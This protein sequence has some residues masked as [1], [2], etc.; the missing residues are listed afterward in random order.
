MIFSAAGP[1]ARSTG[2]MV[3]VIDHFIREHAGQDLLLDFEGSE[4]T[5]LARFYA[6]FG[7]VSVPYQRLVMDR[8]PRAVKMLRRIMR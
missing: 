3:R 6:G 2:A 7:S 1:L 4:N 5:G 8:L